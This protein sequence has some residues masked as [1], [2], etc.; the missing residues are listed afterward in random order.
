MKRSAALG[1]CLHLLSSP[2]ESYNTNIYA[3]TITFER[4]PNH[5]ARD[6]RV[7]LRQSLQWLEQSTYNQPSADDTPG[8]ENA[9]QSKVTLSYKMFKKLVYLI[10]KPHQWWNLRCTLRNASWLTYSVCF[11]QQ[12]SAIFPYINKF[13][14][15]FLNSLFSFIEITERSFW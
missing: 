7:L 4:L 15:I 11:H 9:F 3:E 5:C 1:Y 10:R 6:Q 2:I 14:N 12:E 13:T 8:N